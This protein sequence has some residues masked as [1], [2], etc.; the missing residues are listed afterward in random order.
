MTLEDKKQIQ[1]KIQRNYR[2]VL[3]QKNKVYHNNKRDIL[4]VSIIIFIYVLFNVIKGPG[5]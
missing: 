1:K 4:I 3:N 5:L 2:K